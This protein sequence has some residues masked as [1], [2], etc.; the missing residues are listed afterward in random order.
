MMI[1][2][3]NKYPK[4][5]PRVLHILVGGGGVQSELILVEKSKI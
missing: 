1:P 3:I 4:Y 5:N 2:V